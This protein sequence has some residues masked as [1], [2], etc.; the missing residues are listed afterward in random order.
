[1]NRQR[2]GALI[3]K[4]RKQLFR[5][6]FNMVIGILLPIVLLLIMGYGMSFDVK[7]I[8]LAVVE[9]EHSKLSSEL[10]ARFRGSKYFRVQ[11]FRNTE[12]AVDAMKGHRADVCLFLPRNLPRRSG[13]GPVELMVALN[14]S[15]PQQA[16]LKE[17]YV[18]GIVSETLARGAPE[19]GAVAVSRMWFNETAESLYFMIPGLIVIIISLIGTLLTC[20][21]LAREY[22]HGN[23]ESIF[24]TPV[25]SLEILVAKAL[26][27]FVLGLIGIAITLLTVRYLFHMPMRGSVWI[28]LL[29]CS[30]YLLMALAAGLV[31]SG[32][33]KNQFVACEA[34]MI[35]TF[36]P[37]VLL[38]GFVYEIP[39]LPEAIQY[40]TV[41][42]PGRYFIDFLQTVFLVGDRWGIL[43]MDLAVMTLFTIGMT[44]LAVYKTPKSLEN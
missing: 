19:C 39:N 22:E 20:M 12:D 36:L 24:A 38:S 6:P 21:L 2:L 37:A 41:F 35:V 43:L 18:A 26:N 16:R 11:T 31:I 40:I 25:Q 4:E 23:L 10:I 13:G 42:V 29:G 1:M 14:A 34:T 33:T 15:N 8:E 32:C 17:S 3:A 28:M 7:D 27:N 30:I 5:D 9:P 44:F